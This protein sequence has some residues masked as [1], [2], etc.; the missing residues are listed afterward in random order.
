[1]SLCNFVLNLGALGIQTW[2]WQAFC[3][4]LCVYPVER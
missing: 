4:Q 2:G 3:E 1:L